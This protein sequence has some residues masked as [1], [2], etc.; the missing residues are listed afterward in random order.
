[1]KKCILFS[2]LLTSA[3]THC[4]VDQKV[5]Q[6]QE[7]R[8]QKELELSELGAKIAEKEALLRFMY[9][10]SDEFVAELIQEKKIDG[11]EKELFLKKLNDFYQNFGKIVDQKLA[12]RIDVEHWLAQELFF[13]SENSKTENFDTLKFHVIRDIL[14]RN[15]LKT[16]LARYELCLQELIVID[17]ELDSLKNI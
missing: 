10:K 1:M 3:L 17:R 8:F 16:L 12:T 5:R 11:Q 14:E 4:A 9:L 15:L 6:L 7:V 13:K 2:F